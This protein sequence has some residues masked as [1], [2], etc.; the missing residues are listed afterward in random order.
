M[1]YINAYSTTQHY[2]GPEEGGWYYYV[3]EPIASIPHNV[4]EWT[5]SRNDEFWETI[6]TTRDLLPHI[7]NEDR[8]DIKN[9]EKIL[10]ESVESF[11]FGKLGSVLG[12]NEIKI[13]YQDSYGECSPKNKPFYE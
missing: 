12:G 4:K 8:N 10:S 11:K 1:I 3:D 13:V 7:S 2:G 5:S 6:R 9:K